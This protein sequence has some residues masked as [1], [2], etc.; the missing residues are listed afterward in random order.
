MIPKVD[1]QL[2]ATFQSNPG[3]PPVGATGT[4]QSA[5]WVV[6]NSVVKQ[7][8]GRD[9]SGGAANVTVNLIAPGTV[10]GDRVNQLDVRVAKI[11]KFRRTRTQISLD[12]YN[13]TNADTPLTFNQTFV[14][15]GQWLTPTSIIVARFLKVGAQVDF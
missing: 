6:P 7:T 10:F 11:L 3:L 2:S 5:L 15:G 14:P 13:C 4:D 8:L 12:C 1:V 9:L